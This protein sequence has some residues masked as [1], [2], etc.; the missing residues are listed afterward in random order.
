MFRSTHVL[1]PKC[2]T[3]YAKYD[4]L[5]NKSSLPRSDRCTTKL[6]ASAVIYPIIDP[7]INANA[8][9]P[10]YYKISTERQS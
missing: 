7:G 10:S 9:S 6:R 8:A 5:L 3:L 1:F 2:V 4:N